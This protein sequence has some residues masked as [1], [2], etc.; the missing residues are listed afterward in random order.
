MH[1][2]SKEIIPLKSEVLK[3]LSIIGFRF[4]AEDLAKL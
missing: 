2:F 1:L 3:E 4:F